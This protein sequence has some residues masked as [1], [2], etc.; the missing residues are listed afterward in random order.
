MSVAVRWAGLYAA[1]LFLGA[2]A[3]GSAVVGAG[4]APGFT[5]C[6][7]TCVR[8]MDDTNHCGAC[9][10]RCGAAEVCLSGA[11]RPAMDASV[12]DAGVDGGQRPPLDGAVR[13]GGVRDGS[14]PDA[15]SPDG[16]VP[17]CDVGELRCAGRCVRPSQDPLHCGV[18]DHRCAGGEL[19]ADG[20]CVPICPGTLTRCGDGCVDTLS[21]QDHC[22]VC[23]NAC[24]AGLC[25]LSNCVG[26]PAGHLVLLGHDYVVGRTGFNRLAGNAIFLARRNPVRVL[27]YEG[28]TTATSIAGIT[29]AI[30]QVAGTIGRAWARS[31]TTADEVTLRLSD[32]DVFVIHAQGGASDAELSALSLAWGFALGN[33]ISQGG[34]VVVFETPSATNAG[35]WQVLA[36]EGLFSA[37]GLRTRTGEELRV[38][39]PGDAVANG[40]LSPYRAEENSVAFE[41]ALAPLAE[42]IVWDAD[43]LPVVIHVSDPR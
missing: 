2:G 3:C 40:V 25:R 26:A 38:R 30:D 13:D 20:L 19:C 32:A 15:Q 16:G 31:V 28:V 12:R 7:S 27:A 24:P 17:G 18:C 41:G 33:F 29:A 35:T 43:D 22:G 23:G 37:T 5:A 14:L 39:D 21:D 1:L 42:Q 11:C 36:S 34:T 6:G 10:Q 4:C 8:I 9:G